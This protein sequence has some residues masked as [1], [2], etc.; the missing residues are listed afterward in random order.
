MGKVPEGRVIVATCCQQER[1]SPLT[2]FRPGLL[3]C[4]RSADGTYRSHTYGA[5]EDGWLQL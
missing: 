1:T 3:L 4:Y 5:Y 2:F